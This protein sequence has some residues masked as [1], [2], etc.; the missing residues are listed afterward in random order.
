[1]RTTVIQFAGFQLRMTPLDSA[2]QYPPDVKTTV[3][4][5]TYRVQR[6]VNERL[7]KVYACSSSRNVLCLGLQR[8]G[9]VVRLF[10][11]EILK[12]GKRVTLSIEEWR[13]VTAALLRLRDYDDNRMNGSVEAEVLRIIKR[14]IWGGK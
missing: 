11:E 14:A 4:K 9:V 13:V 6:N 3:P 8:A 7:Y 10:Q 2:T 1:M 5:L 12:M